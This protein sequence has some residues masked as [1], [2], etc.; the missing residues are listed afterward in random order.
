MQ[1]RDYQE[2]AIASIRQHYEKGINK[3]VVVMATGLGKT[4]VFA[5]LISQLIKE[6]G[7]KALII[8]H[9][10]E[11]LTQAKDKLYKVDPTLN[12]DIEQATNHAHSNAD[13]IIASVPTLGRAN[14]T[15]IQKFDPN[16]FCIAV[17][18]EAH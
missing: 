2:K 6:T 12:A 8:A 17:T 3:Q 13:V 16:E 18:D 14:S 4:I 7:K 15:R 1:L 11:L 9:R 5:Y 10:E